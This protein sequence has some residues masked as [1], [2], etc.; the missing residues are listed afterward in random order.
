[1][2]LNRRQ[3]LVLGGMGG[4]GL[5]F[6]GRGLSRP[7]TSPIEFT[8]LPSLPPQPASQDLVLRFVAIADSGSGAKDQLAVGKAMANHH[9]S[10]PYSLVVMAGDNIYDQGEIERVGVTF[11]QPYAE[12][13]KR[14]VRFQAALGNHDIRTA[15]GD[16]QV[17]YPAFNMKGRYYTYREKSV[18]FFV[19][20]TNEWQPQLA[21]LEA[22]LKRSDAS[23]KIVYGHHPIYSSGLYGTNPEMVKAF[24]PLFKKYQVQLYLNGH[25]HNYERTQPIDGTTYLI[26][27]H[28]GATLRSVKRSDWTAY[29]TSRFGFSVV[30]IYP[31]RMEIQG[32]GANGLVYD[33]GSVPL[34]AAQT[35]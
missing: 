8:K 13:L 1:M 32:I 24:T 6:V 9:Q 23:T 25:E 15:N 30:E 10:H 4:L 27:G 5:A 20:D 34:K 22:E 16:L 14:G 12:L 35:A 26:T 33:R 11:E 3:L 28:G 7:V 18:Q 29:S 2:R 17:E 31:D 21:W 19:L